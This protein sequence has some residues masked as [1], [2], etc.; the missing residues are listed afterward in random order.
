VEK[1]GIVIMAVT[2]EWRRGGNRS[3]GWYEQ[4][5]TKDD[6]IRAGWSEAGMLSTSRGEWV[7]FWRPCRKGKSFNIST[8]NTL[9]R[10]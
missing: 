2:S 9:P 5:K 3:G 1:D 6:L 4:C 8:V 10:S 7:L